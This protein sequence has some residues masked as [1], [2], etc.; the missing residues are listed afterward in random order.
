MVTNV[1]LDFYRFEFKYILSKSIRDEIERELGY[2]MDIDPYVSENME[3]KYKVRS[4]YYDDPSFTAY[5]EKTDGI[6]TR[7]KFRVRTYTT[8]FSE[9]CSTFL[10]IKGRHNNL[11]FKHRVPLDKGLQGQF[12]MDEALDC[13]N[14]LS[15]LS[16][17]DSLVKDRFEYDSIRRRLQ[18]IMLIDYERRPMISKYDSEFRLTFDDS[19]MGTA[20]QCLYPSNRVVG[21]KILPQYTILEIKFRHSLPKW[22]H[23]IIQS[24][25]LTR[26]SV[27]KVCSGIEVCEL[28]KV[29]D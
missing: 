22:F 23:R 27:S 1:K 7:S 16:G 8:D 20:T 28:T 21:K 19:L 17:T 6:R 14:I 3:A 25:N 10:E 29:Y 26:V 15:R 9:Q 12:N 5:Y 11:V 2:F 13:G 24:Y 4:L 18:P